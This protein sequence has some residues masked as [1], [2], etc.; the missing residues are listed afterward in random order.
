MTTQQQSLFAGPAV[1]T[2]Y[3]LGRYGE[4]YAYVPGSGDLDQ[5]CGRGSKTPEFPNGTYAYFL[6]IDAA[7]N[8][9]FPS[10]STGRCTGSPTVRGR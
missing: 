2:S 8:P 10:S 9:T 4:D 3:P 5:F 6:P 1:S 7:G